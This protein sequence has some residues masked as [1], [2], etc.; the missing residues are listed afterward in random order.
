MYG[1]HNPL[2]RKHAQLN[3][4]NLEQ[5]IAFVFASIRVQTA[6]LPRMMKEF[7]KRGVK[8]S[9]IWGNKRTGIDYVRKHRQD[10]FDRMTSILRAKKA[11]CAHDL[12]MLFL[13]VPGLGLPKAGFVVQL[14]SGKSGCMDVHNF[15]KY[16]PEVDASKGTPSWLQTS[17]NS[18]KTK[19]F[20]AGVYL[21][22]IESN[23]GSAKFWNNWCGHISMLYPHHFPT[24][25]DVSKLHMCIW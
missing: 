16:L 15:R 2:V 7:R 20:K 24:P 22:L 1:T 9:W 5:V 14:V 18:D 12:M 23:G 6:M 19:R 21:D 17:G 11:N 3:A 25:E 8:S 4:K 10:L 13:E